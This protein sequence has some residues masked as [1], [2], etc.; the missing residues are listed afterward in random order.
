[1]ERH[2]PRGAEFDV[3]GQVK[4]DLRV[5][6]S[7]SNLQDIVTYDT[8]SPSQQGLPFDGIAH[9]A[10][11]AWATWEPH[12]GVMRGLTVGGGFNSH[13]GEHY[14]QYVSLPVYSSNSTACQQAV[15]DPT[16]CTTGFEDDRVPAASLVNLMAAYHHNWGQKRLSVQVNIRN[17]IDRYNFSSIGYE[18]AL[19]NTPF[20]IMPE[21]EFKF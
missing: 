18:G 4:R 11:S 3:S 8:N 1:M 9:V 19:P 2:A 17:L 5:I 21:L 14:F 16:Q 15:V 13:S 20:Q 7:F 10:G 12:D 6:A